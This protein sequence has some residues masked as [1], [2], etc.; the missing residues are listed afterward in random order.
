MRDQVVEFAAAPILGA[1]ELHRRQRRRGLC[2]WQCRRVDV[3]TRGLRE[4]LD[5]VGVANHGCAVPTESLAQRDQLQRNLVGSE[6]RFGNAATAI[7]THDADTMRVIDVQEGF[8]HARGQRKF[9]HRRDIAIH[10]EDAIGGEHRDA[11]AG[12]AQQAQRTAGIAMWIAAQLAASQARG[13]DQARV[14][15]AVLH[16]DVV[17][18]EQRLHHREVGHEAAAEQ[19]GARRAEPVSKLLLQ[20]LVHRV[21]AADQV[22]RHAAGAFA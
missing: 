10:A 4:V 7:G 17:V 15:E 16:A 20:C 6:L 18:A 8:L 22:R 21:V 5:Q 13:V 9:A 14:V 1:R 2:R 12:L 3:G 11:V 19:Q